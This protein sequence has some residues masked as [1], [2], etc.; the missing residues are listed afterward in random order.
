MK[1][2]KKTQKKI[3]HSIK[4]KVS[5]LCASFIIIA[6]TI[7]YSLIVNVSSKIIKENT[8]SAL[9][10]LAESSKLNVTNAL[11]RVG[12]SANFITN[13]DSVLSYIKSGG[14]E[15]TEET[16]RFVTMFTN[17]NSSTEKISLVDENGIVLLSSDK[18][19]I[20]TD[21][22]SENYYTTMVENK[23]T[24]QSNVTISE[25]SNEACVTFAIP[26]FETNEGDKQVNGELDNQAA[27]NNGEESTFTPDNTNS[28][29]PST[30]DTG[31]ENSPEG[32][33]DTMNST[34]AEGNTQPTQ[35]N[36]IGS[37]VTYV[38]V[39]EFTNTLSEISLNG[40]DSSYAYL[41]DSNG[42]I[43]YHPT[44]EKIG[45]TVE[46]SAVNNLIETTNEETTDTSGLLSYTYNGV[47][48][49]ASYSLSSSNN[50]ILIIAADQSEV[51]SSLNSATQFSFY[52]S[53][54]IVIILGVIAYIITGFIT[55][56]IK[57]ITNLIKKTAYL[58]FSE[59][60][61]LEHLEKSKDE[62][63]DMATALKDMRHSIREMIEQINDAS[64][65]ITNNA[66]HLNKITNKVNE[67][68]TNNSTTAEE[69]A[70]G[71]EE[72]AATTEMIHENILHVK[73]S[74]NS[75]NEKATEG[76]ELSSVLIKRATSLKESTSI[77]TEKTYEMYHNIKN[78]TE[79][80]IEQAKAVDKI[81]TLAKTIMDIAD[82]TSLLALNA[83]IEAARAGD[84]GRGFAVVA[85]EIGT[86]ADQSAHTV[87]NITNI[88][89]EVNMAVHSMTTSLEQTIDFLEKRVLTDYNEFIQVSD[90]YNEDA[91]NINDNMSS[92][93]QA[94]DS[95]NTTMLHIT[96]SIS[97]INTMMGESSHGIID[98]TNKSASI[99]DLT[100]DTYHMAKESNSFAEKLQNIVAK[101][102]L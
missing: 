4:T 31:A 2:K 24:S 7:S 95:L 33:K 62:T 49:L 67:H 13:S 44:E 77:A 69:L 28:T 51:L 92:I 82:Q 40:I 20:G 9:L 38:K 90:Q 3:L 37:I 91:K 68:A 29:A 85:N 41:I 59:D 97:E 48:K 86:L 66:S 6:V 101:F 58:D 78:N 81:N 18:S 50:W 54:A 42:T 79:S 32:N 72:T 102:K 63:G 11:S 53:C 55:K 45:T 16:E 14:T 46:N 15:N 27:T 22:S 30:E 89:Q 65:D 36:I 75:I 60:S 34:N 71:M 52:I 19:L 73:N 80:A 47:K 100:T 74:S 57:N 84:S 26:V 61:T 87:S 96:E 99:L 94:V 17:M 8:E 98:V 76:T 93:Q 83:S 1:Q 10:N 23:T 56:P 12:E 25:D 5:L 21:L 35:G 43:I 39:S 88:I 70:A 64:T